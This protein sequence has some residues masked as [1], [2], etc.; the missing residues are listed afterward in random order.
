MTGR[1]IWLFGPSGAGKSTLAQQLY[2]LQDNAI[3]LDGDEMRKT[4]SRDL[5]F[6]VQDRMTH[7]E[8]M[9]ITAEALSNH[10]YTVICSF[11]TPTED[12]R[13]RVNE[14]VMNI[15][16]VWIHAPSKRKDSIFETPGFYHTKCSIFECGTNSRNG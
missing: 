3:W 1:V 10:D 15:L 14:I 4:I 9:A 5:S 13:L 12:M 11:I 2:F 7:L 8:R 6:T 16:W